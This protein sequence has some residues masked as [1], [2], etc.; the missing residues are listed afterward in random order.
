MITSSFYA[1]PFESPCE[2]LDKDGAMPWFSVYS[3]YP[4]AKLSRFDNFTLD[5][6]VNVNVNTIIQR[7]F[8]EPP[9]SLHAH[10]SEFANRVRTSFAKQHA[11]AGEGPLEA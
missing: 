1:W 6:D 10:D 8:S 11:M 7:T 9:M 3:T 5:V 4:D 2:R